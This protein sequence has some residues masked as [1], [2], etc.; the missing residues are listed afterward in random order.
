MHRDGQYGQKHRITIL[1]F[2]DKYRYAYDVSLHPVPQSCE[3][4][5]SFIRRPL[6]VRRYDRNIISRYVPRYTP[7]IAQSVQDFV[8]VS[9]RHR[10]VQKCRFRCCFFP[11]E[12]C[13]LRSFSRFLSRRATRLGEIARNRSAPSFSATSVGKRDVFGRARVRRAWI[14]ELFGVLMTSHDASR[15]RNRR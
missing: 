7:C 15:G 11:P 10:C 1:I 14:R 5:Q 4:Q 9:F 3:K 2:N 12:I 6:E 13:N 8:E